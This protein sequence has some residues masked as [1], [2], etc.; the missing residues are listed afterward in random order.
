M[1]SSAKPFFVVS[2]PRS[3]STLLRLI[4][5]SH[6]ALAVPPPGWLFDMIY[7]YLYSYGD[8]NHQAN[9]LALAED[10][11]QTPTVGRWPIKL[12]PE[13]LVRVA[14]ESSFAGL[15]AA[16]HR[17]YAQAEGKQCWGEKTPRNSFWMDEIKALFP[18]AQFIH[19][20]RDGRDQAIDISDSI[21]L[22]YSLYSGAN[23][24]QRH[25]SAV[26]DSA[27][28]LPAGAYLEIRYED[29]CAAPEAVIRKLCA[30]LDV[31]FDARML[32]PHE[33]RSARNWSAHPLH[34]KTAQ[35][36]ST[37]FCEMY[38]TRMPSADIAALEALIGATLQCFGYP[39]SGAG[40]PIP[41][42]LAAQMIESDTVTNPENVA[43]KRWHEERRKRRREQ[44]VWRDSDR[45]SILWGT[46]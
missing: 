23:L 20:V 12:A 10:I 24:W 39:L 36:I 41:Q 31:E 18:D 30:F 33:T 29:L 3:G 15:Y 44:G 7:P 9:L 1:A 5:D 8:L 2:A 6:S 4:L 19:I 25:V 14:A 46:N 38:K 22:P 13:E 42:R 32:T 26:R 40:R 17:A 37:R 35:P 27:S 21:L 43:Y 28:R 34:A 11:L 16:L 45:K